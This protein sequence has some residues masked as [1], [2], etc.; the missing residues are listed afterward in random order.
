MTHTFINVS[1][2][3]F[4]L[5]GNTF[6]KTFL[7]FYI[8][9]SHIRIYNIYDSKLFLINT[10]HVSDIT[11]D[12]VVYATATELINAIHEVL[13]TK[14]T[15]E[16]LTTEQIE[17]NRLAIIDLQNT[18]ANGTH[19][20]DSRYYT[21]AQV[22][23]LITEINTAGNIANGYVEGDSIKFFDVSGNQVLTI[24]AHNFV[25][26]GVSVV[27][28]DGI[29]YLKNSNG[30]ILSTTPVKA[31]ETFYDRFMFVDKLATDLSDLVLLSNFALG[32]TNANQY[33]FVSA[34]SNEEN[35]IGNRIYIHEENKHFDL[36]SPEIVSNDFKAWSINIDNPDYLNGTIYEFNFWI[37]S[38]TENANSSFTALNDTPTSFTGNA[39]KILAVNESE[40]GVGFVSYSMQKTIVSDITL[41]DNYDGCIVKIKDNV[42]II[43]SN[44]LRDN[45]NCVFRSFPSC[46][47]FFTPSGTTL[48]APKGI[49]LKET[50]MATLFKDGT[51]NIYILE[52]EL[53]DDNA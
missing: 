53:S 16:E 17:L 44:N 1:S 19:N 50:A 37:K 33:Y 5:N 26:Q 46:S 27:F 7:P 30:T 20:H 52:G 43:I 13:F 15:S 32:C 4:S 18:K 31:R 51:D 14:G 35:F 45:F 3:K 41:T 40:D 12:G 38:R 29:L 2:S 6:F 42:N 25:R 49:F 22:D 34:I 8:D 21:Q 23:A 36:E 9:N 48:D 10:T 11:V 28:E 47:A 24:D 39:G